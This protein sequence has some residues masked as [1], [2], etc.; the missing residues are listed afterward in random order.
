MILARL[1]YVTERKENYTPVARQK[2]GYD[3]ELTKIIPKE[4]AIFRQINSE[5]TI[6]TSIVE[7][8]E[9]TKENITVI[10]KNTKYLFKML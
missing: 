3:F 1:M 8:I 7:S 4:S 2:I 9:I 6:L 5:C 10:S